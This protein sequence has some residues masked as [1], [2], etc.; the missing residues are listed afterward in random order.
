MRNNK[1][2]SF[3]DSIAVV[4]LLEKQEVCKVLGGFNAAPM[5]DEPID[6]G[7]LGEVE[8]PVPGDDGGGEGPGPGNPGGDPGG[9]WSPPGPG[10]SG[11]GSGGG[12]GGAG[13]P[14]VSDP[15][16]GE[17]QEP[18]IDLSGLQDIAYHINL[19]E[20]V[21]T[22]T[23]SVSHAQGNTLTQALTWLS[24]STGV[25]ISQADV[26]AYYM[27]VKLP[28]GITNTGGVLSALSTIGH[29]ID[30][31]ETYN[32]SS[33]GKTALGLTAT[34]ASFTPGGQPIAFVAGVGLFIWELVDEM[35]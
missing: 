31:A 35:D 5:N 12:G 26:S 34:I 17:N 15:P 18:A 23:V 3:N 24:N 33:G 30:F 28:K 7:W 1:R 27:K 6:G 8:I 13:D 20:V 14:G 2:L 21:V 29:A 32:F 11:G 19:P 16:Y 4:E 10:D 22:A 9:P 25:A